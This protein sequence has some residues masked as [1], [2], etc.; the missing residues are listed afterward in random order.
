MKTALKVY[1]SNRA[2]M[3]NL[4]P[5][6]LLPPH[7]MIGKFF[8]QLVIIDGY[9]ALP[10]SMRLPLAMSILKECKD[11]LLG[12]KMIFEE[13]FLGFLETSNFLFAFFDELAQA[14]VAIEQNSIF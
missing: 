1:S 6:E 4:S 13:S 3:Q 2:L 12:A 9:R 8:S 14:Q 10:K 11:K 7:M 5:D